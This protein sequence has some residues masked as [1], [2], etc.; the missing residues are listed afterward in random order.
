MNMIHIEKI[1]REELLEIVKIMNDWDMFLQE[2]IGDEKY[3]L[4]VGEWC[5]DKLK[6]ESPEI[7][8]TLYPG[9]KEDP[10]S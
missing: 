4:I 7:F 10:K 9:E 5:K 1:S 6:R 8:K 2:Y 3:K